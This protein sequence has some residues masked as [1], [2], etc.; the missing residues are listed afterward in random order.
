M[1]VEF[2]D[3][4]P[5]KT[6]SI[7]TDDVRFALRSRP[8]EWACV[9]RSSKSTASVY[10]VAKRDPRWQARTVSAG[11]DEQGRP[12]VDLYMRWVGDSDD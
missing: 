9:A 5:N 3:P 2:V 7:V 12:L 1:S 11:K 4:P 8:G 10:G 6:R